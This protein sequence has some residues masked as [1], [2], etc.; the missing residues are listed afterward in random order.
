MVRCEFFICFV[1]IKFHYYLGLVKVLW[2]HILE[3]Q[4]VNEDAMSYF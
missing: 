3:M 2:N 4:I 1:F